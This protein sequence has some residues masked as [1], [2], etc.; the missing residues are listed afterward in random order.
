[1]HRYSTLTELRIQS[2]GLVRSNLR[3]E[4]AR[5]PLENVADGFG[6]NYFI[7]TVV[8]AI[9]A[10]AVWPAIFPSSEAFAV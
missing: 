9:A 3:S 2:L 5:V 8:L 1:M 4:G 10:M 6:A 7:F